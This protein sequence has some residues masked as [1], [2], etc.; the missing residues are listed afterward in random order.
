MAG[1]RFIPLILFFALL[2]CETYVTYDQEKKDF[3]V[4]KGIPEEGSITIEPGE[5]CETVDDVFVVC[6]K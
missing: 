2:G 6:G 1:T 3:V 5:N 4:K